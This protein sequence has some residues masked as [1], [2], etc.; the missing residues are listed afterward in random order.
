MYSKNNTEIELESQTIKWLKKAKKKLEEHKNKK[1]QKKFIIK[2]AD[3]YIKDTYYFLEQND[4]IRGFESI[5]WA[6]ALLE[7]G[8]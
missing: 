6:W 8:E 1:N 2:N 7:I 3:C 4:Y 5:I